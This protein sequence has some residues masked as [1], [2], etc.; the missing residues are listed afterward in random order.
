MADNT[1]KASIDGTVR[2]LENI[3]ETFVEQNRSIATTMNTIKDNTRYLN[4]IHEDTGVMRDKLIA[5]ERDTQISLKIN[6]G[7]LF[8]L[9]GGLVAIII[10][11]VSYFCF[12]R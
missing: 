5:I 9:I 2:K 3:M 1:N 7:M 6:W 8:A 10:L 11:F 12:G 4:D